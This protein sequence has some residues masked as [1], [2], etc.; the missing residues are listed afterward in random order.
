MRSPV[1]GQVSDLTGSFRLYRKRCLDKLMNLC[2]SKGYAFQ[3]EIVVRARGLGFTIE[4]V[5][6]HYRHSDMGYAFQMEIVVRARPGL[7]DRGGEGAL[8]QAP[9]SSAAARTACR[10]LRG[11]PAGS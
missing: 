5:R 9:V 10:G 1:P 6:V 3:M 7:N 4:E 8:L 2:T 11:G